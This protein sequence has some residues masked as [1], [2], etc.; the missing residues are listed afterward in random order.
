[1]SNII[2][3]NAQPGFYLKS[4]DFLKFQSTINESDAIAAATQPDSTL[5][6]GRP[7]N[8]LTES[9]VYSFMANG[10]TPA[11][12]DELFVKDI[13]RNEKEVKQVLSSVGVK[14]I[15]QKAFDGLVSMQNQL[16]NIS[17]AFVKGE[18]IDLTGL[19]R[20]GDWDRVASFIAADERDRPRRIQ[21]ATMIANG[22]YGPSVDQAQIIK[23]G[24]DLA[25]ERLAKEQLNKQTGTPATDQQK[26]A[27][28]NSYF[29]ANQT[30]LPGASTPLKLAAA[31]NFAE[32]YI[33][34][35]YKRQA[36][37]WPY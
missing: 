3:E 14:S 33:T 2:P 35:R 11:A 8:E 19:Y 16:G 7:A 34:K 18:K 15:P 9:Q 28:A 10:V 6:V 37:P 29:S 30:S 26:V 5:K 20:V 36:G 27:L 25:N 22:D 31:K 23:K 1:M 24:F 12:A 21:E 13:S 32:E 4:Q 17:Y